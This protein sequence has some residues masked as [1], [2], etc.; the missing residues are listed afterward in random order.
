MKKEKIQAFIR[1]T[2]AFL[3]LGIAFCNTH[4]SVFVIL[5]LITFRIEAEDWIKLTKK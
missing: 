3:L 4:W 2:L 1:W 5:L